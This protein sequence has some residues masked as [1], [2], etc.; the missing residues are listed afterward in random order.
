MASSSGTARESASVGTWYGGNEAGTSSAAGNFSTNGS[1][2]AS[3]AGTGAT[4]I[5]GGTNRTFTEALLKAGLKKSYEL[6]AN[7]DVAMISA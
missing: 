4:A 7:P 2:S 6:G 3:P 1:P 5:A